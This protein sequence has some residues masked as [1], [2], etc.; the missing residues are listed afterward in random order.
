MLVKYSRETA[1]DGGSQSSDDGHRPIPKS[2]RV[3][4][5]YQNPCKK[6]KK[7]KQKK[8]EKNELENE[9]WNGGEREVRK[10]EKGRRTEKRE[11]RERG[12]KKHWRGVALLEESPQNQPIIEEGR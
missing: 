8:K 2:S 10:R 4:C 12:K 1:T 9:K 6:N 11:K 3:S 7:R 5:L